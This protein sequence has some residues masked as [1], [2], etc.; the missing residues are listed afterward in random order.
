MQPSGTPETFQIKK[1][2]N[3]RYYDAT[4]SR[5]ITL[6]EVYELVRDGSDIA[7]TDSRT[8]SDITNL[9]L[10]Q[11]LLDRDQ[12]K[13]CALPPAL[14]HSLIRAQDQALGL[15][16][17]RHADAITAAVGR[18]PGTPRA[19]R[20]PIEADSGDPAPKQSNPPQ[21]RS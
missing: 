13:L 2:P 6:Q 19:D 5:H 8:D 11:I 12:P 14:L 1:Y 4:R 3:R 7:V 17:D 20:E 21:A 15:L 9:I 16:V 10:V 18:L